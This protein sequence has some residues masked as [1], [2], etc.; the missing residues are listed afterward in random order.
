LRAWPARKMLEPKDIV[1]RGVANPPKDPD[2]PALALAFSR[3][4]DSPASLSNERGRA[5]RPGRAWQE[6][7]D[8]AR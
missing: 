6:A 7:G 5:E 3:S 1:W 8:R 4:H 2:T